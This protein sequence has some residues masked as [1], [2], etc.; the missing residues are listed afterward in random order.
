MADS[1]YL[2]LWFPDF[3]EPEI[4]PRTVSVL[5][6]FPFSP[7]Q[8]GVT[9]VAVQPVSWN[10]PTILERRFRPG[11]PPEEAAGVAADLLHDD[12]AYVFEA[13]WDLWSPPD[14]GDQWALQPT[15]VQFIAQGTEFEDAAAADTGHIQIDFG[16][17]T[18]FLHEELSLT[19]EAE[20]GLR[21]NVYKLVEFTAK[22]EKNAGATGRL[23]WSESEENL[24][25]KLIARLQK[26]N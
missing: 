5:R 11:V 3:G 23:L 10:E 18:S 19:P 26:V 9:Y 20:Q 24:A 12:Y 2:S 8:D 22:V 17:D 4:L 16:L 25:R 21:N 13:Y 14:R 7:A 15:L 6:Q 1:L